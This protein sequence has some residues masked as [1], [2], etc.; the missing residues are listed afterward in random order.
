MSR[1]LGLLVPMRP[2]IPLLSTE[3]KGRE[4]FIF[5]GGTKER[6]A[7]PQAPAHE[8]IEFNGVTV[9]SYGTL[10]QE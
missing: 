6:P 4:I 5:G 3:G 10:T 2:I 7:F 9:R 1:T 8:L